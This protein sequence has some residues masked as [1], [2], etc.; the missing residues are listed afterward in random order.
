MLVIEN[1]K[2]LFDGL[3]CVFRVLRIVVYN[4]GVLLHS[5]IFGRHVDDR[6]PELLARTPPALFVHRRQQRAEAS[7]FP[8]TE[9]W[10]AN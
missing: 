3:F 8:R 2:P 5:T 4:L 7:Q 10:S 6:R 9:L 1:A